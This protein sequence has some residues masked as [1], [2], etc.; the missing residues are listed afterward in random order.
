MTNG[1]AKSDSRSVEKSLI[2]ATSDSDCNSSILASRN[3]IDLSFG[4]K[5]FWDDIFSKFRKIKKGGQKGGHLWP[6]NSAH[7]PKLPKIIKFY[8]NL[9][10]WDVPTLPPLFECPPFLHPNLIRQNVMIKRDIVDDVLE[11]CEEESSSTWA[12]LLRKRIDPVQTQNLYLFL[13]I[14]TNITKT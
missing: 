4:A 2:F 9:N 7:A 14:F 6:S 10:I 8:I 5:F 3:G 1:E 13:L 12:V 11:G